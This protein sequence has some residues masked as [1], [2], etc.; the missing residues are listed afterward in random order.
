MSTYVPKHMRGRAGRLNGA[1]T[2][3]TALSASRSAVAVGVAGAVPI[4]AAG[5]LAAP[6]LADR[7]PSSSQDGAPQRVLAYGANGQ[8]VATV[9]GELALVRDGAFGPVTAAAVKDFQRAN[10]LEVD[11]VVGT[12]T[13]AALAGTGVTTQDGVLA[14]GSTGPLVRAVQKKLGVTVDGVYGDVTEAAVMTFQKAKGL[15]ADGVVGTDTTYALAQV[16]GSASSSKTSSSASSSSASTTSDASARASRSTTAPAKAAPA[17]AASTTPSLV[18]P[19]AMYELPFPAG[20]AAMVSQGPFGVASHH[21]YNDKHH[22][23]FAV[24]TGTPIVASASGVVYRTEYT[25]SGGNAIYIRDASGYCMEYAH[26]SSFNVVQGQRVS[27]GQGIALSGATG[28]VTGPH[29]HW[30]IIDCSSYT[31]IRIADTKE[32]GTTYT[33]GS[34]LVSR[35]D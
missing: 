6:A 30:G 17:K 32:A 35:N 9:Q 25:E 10:N 31:S 11:G 20:Y 7:A 2:S 19:N 1:R 14:Q 29:L 16:S 22:V 8:D 13:R 24:P 21:K 23:D 27:R 4:G 3:V 15:D 12:Q 34:V 26:L 18:D 5:V 33:V 28:H